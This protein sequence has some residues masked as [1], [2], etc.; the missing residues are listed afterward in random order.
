MLCMD[1][2][3]IPYNSIDLLL[4]RICLLF[5]LYIIFNFKLHPSKYLLLKGKSIGVDFASQREAYGMIP[6]KFPAF[7]ACRLPWLPGNSCTLCPLCM[8]LHNHTKC[9]TQVQPL[10]DGLKHTLNLITKC[11]KFSFQNIP[12]TKAGYGDRQRTSLRT[13]SRLLESEWAYL[14]G[15]PTNS[16]SSVI[17]PTTSIRYWEIKDRHSQLILTVLRCFFFGVPSSAYPLYMALNS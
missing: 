10:L 12:L 3:V 4:C 6:A 14:T 11:T 17:N 8:A 5:H 1:D 7:S 2:V 16:F 13:S 9:A 15:P